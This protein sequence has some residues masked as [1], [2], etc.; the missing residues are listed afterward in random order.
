MK[1]FYKTVAIK[2]TGAAFAITLDERPVKTPGGATLGLHTAA[3]A[4]AIAAEWAGQ[5]EKIDQK[6]MP[7]TR[8]ANTAQDHVARDRDTTLKQVETFARH[9]LVCYRA[10]EPPVLAARE[11]QAWDAPLAWA[12]ARYGLDLNATHGVGSIDQPGVTPAAIA[13]A[14]SRFDAFGLTGLAAAAGIMKSL[15]LALSLADGRLDAAGAHA[16]AHVDETFQAEKWGR[17]SEAEAR[18]KT[19]LHELQDAERF[20]RLAAA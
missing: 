14:L 3:L 10:A 6:T 7:L 16:A 11:A 18:L 15:V 20:M 8:L 4:E 12:R 19:L 5:G 1:R 17:D 9:D 13:R 2:Q